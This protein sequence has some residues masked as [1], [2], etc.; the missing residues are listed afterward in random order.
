MYISVSMYGYSNISFYI[1]LAILPNSDV[2]LI[3]TSMY[4]SA[5]M[6]KTFL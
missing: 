4:D 3:C 5:K 1:S 6:S 2:K